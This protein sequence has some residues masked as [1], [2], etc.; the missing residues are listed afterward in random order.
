VFFRLPSECHVCHQV[1]A[2]TSGPDVAELKSAPHVQS[3]HHEIELPDGGMQ[4]PLVAVA[5]ASAARE[6]PDA[7]GAGGKMLFVIQYLAS[8]WDVF[9]YFFFVCTI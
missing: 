3:E 5:T 7:S 4:S 8:Q 9:F 2:V 6:T 1:Q